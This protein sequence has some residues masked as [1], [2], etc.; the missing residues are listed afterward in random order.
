MKN[1][2]IAIVSLCFALMWGCTAD[3][4]EVN[5]RL[6]D[7]EGRVEVLERLCAQMNTNIE[8][9]Q[10]LLDAVQNNDYITSVTP[11]EEGGK[12]IG[13]TITFEKN[14]PITI[15]Y[16][17][18]G[19]DGKDGS[20]PQIG[21]RQ[22]AD[23]VYYWTLNGEWLT[24]GDGNKVPARGEDGSQGDTGQTGPKGEDGLTPQL[25]IENGYWW[26]SYDGLQW[27][28]VGPAV[29][30]SQSYEI[31]TGVEIINSTV[32]FYLSDGTVLAVPMAGGLDIIFDETVGIEC[33]PG[34]TVS[35]PYQVVGGDYQAVVECLG[36][37]GW[38]GKVNATDAYSGTIEVTAPEGDETEGKILVFVS[39]AGQ[40]IVRTLLFN[41]RHLKAVAD[42]WYIEDGSASEVTFE[43]RTNIAIY[44]IGIDPE[45]EDW[46]TYLPETKSMRTDYLTFSVAEYPSGTMRE[47]VIYIYDEEAGEFVEELYIYQQSADSYEYNRI[48]E[49]KDLNV[50]ARLVAVA[51][52]NGDN[53][54]SYGEAAD[55]VQL[56]SFSESGYR[57]F[58]EFRYFT[59]WEQ[60]P[61]GIFS[62]CPDLQ[63]L[64]LPETTTLIQAGAFSGCGDQETQC[65]IEFTSAVPPEVEPGAFD[66]SNVRI[67]V[68]EESLDA[69]L[70]SDLAPYIV[71][72]QLLS[73]D[74][75]LNSAQYDRIYIDVDSPDES[76]A[77][78]VSYVMLEEWNA[79]GG[80]GVEV[81]KSW[82]ESRGMQLYDYVTSSFSAFVGSRDGLSATYL[83]P[84]TEY[85]FFAVSMTGVRF[86]QSGEIYLFDCSEP[87]MVRTD[88]T[89]PAVDWYGTWHVTASKTFSALEGTVVDS[90]MEFDVEIF[91]WPTNN[92]IVMTGW[93]PELETRFGKPLP[94]GMS[95]DDSGYLYLTNNYND[96]SLT[97]YLGYSYPEEVEWMILAD[98]YT[99][100]YGG[101]SLQREG[102]NAEFIWDAYTMS[103]LEVLTFGLFYYDGNAWSVM[104]ETSPSGEIT[105]TKVSDEVTA[106]ASRN[107]VR[108]SG[109]QTGKIQQPVTQTGNIRLK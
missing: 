10:T 69:Y 65:L 85:V 90:P 47:A 60:I 87:L 108:H 6:D 40:T 45:A 57:W 92:T 4:D 14:G 23:G 98:D 89:D 84:D 59:L 9:L 94:F 78:I 19:E 68:P 12:V 64:V 22:D 72:E 83:I 13:Y 95:Y 105:M 15:Y 71:P 79:C 26:V 3:L 80:S 104:S 27:T 31:F 96:V 18:D 75:T 29:S 33:A 73:L 97:D 7:L 63:Y 93:L 82:A 86:D 8:S 109:G 42:S 106:V 74:I 46:V 88:A 30:E 1:R 43:L 77:Y 25:K 16:G 55:C 41:G 91:R 21:I 34:Q 62:D 107:T 56:P 52:M 51:D 81:M 99:L 50:K 76:T 37:G 102:D 28:E 35:I 67:V 17:E 54:I 2:L 24:D 44:G 66:G 32:Y 48:I 49:F 11:I 38:T 103:G 39:S 5:S 20:V 53:E 61:E 36:Q 70:A 100:Y 58:G 101:V